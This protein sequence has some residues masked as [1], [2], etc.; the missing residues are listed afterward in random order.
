MCEIN[1]ES[2]RI[3]LCRASGPN[4]KITRVRKHEKKNSGRV[5][6]CAGPV[7]PPEELYGRC[8]LSWRSYSVTQRG[9]GPWLGYLLPL[10]HSHPQQFR[11]CSV[12]IRDFLLCSIEKLLLM[13]LSKHLPYFTF[14][15]QVEWH[16]YVSGHFSHLTHPT[17]GTHYYFAGLLA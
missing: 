17:S 13:T 9:K 11:C 10:N 16:S 12:K 4:L 6:R 3:I 14:G 15:G 8:R 7:H 1:V 2:V 5:K